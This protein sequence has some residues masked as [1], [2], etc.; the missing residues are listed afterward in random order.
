[1]FFVISGFVI[2]NSFLLGEQSSTRLAYLRDFWFRRF[3]RLWPGL[4]A[5]VATSSLF[6]VITNLARPGSLLTGLSSLVGLSNF[7]L[8]VGR[9]EYFALDTNSDWFMHLWSLSVEEQ[10]YLI[11][12]IV[13]M[14]VVP[15]N[16]NSEKKIARFRILAISLFFLTTISLTFALLPTTP[17]LI[18]FYSP[19]TRFY[20]VGF[21]ALIAVFAS[22]RPVIVKRDGPGWRLIVSQG[23]RISAY[24]GIAV[25]IFSD[26]QPTRIGS[27][28]MTAFTATAVVFKDHS[29]NNSSHLLSQLLKLVGDRSYSIYLV[30]W[31]IQLFSQIILESGPYRNL[32]NL[33]LTA[34][35][36][37]LN[38]R[39][40]EERFRNRHLTIRRKTA[41]LSTLFSVVTTFLVLAT[42]ILISEARTRP[43][44]S[45]PIPHCDQIDGSWWLIGD[46]HLA[47]LQSEISRVSGSQCKVIGGRGLVFDYTIIDESPDGRQSQRAVLND[48]APLIRKIQNSEN[49]PKVLLIAH[50]LSGYLPDPATAP[51]SSNA[52]A[53]EWS[54]HDGKKISRT[55][56]MA[57]F[58]RNLRHLAEVLAVRNAYLVVVS[59]PPDFD[60][61]RYYVDPAYCTGRLF[62]SRECVMTRS[63]AQIT[64]EEHELRSGEYRRLLNL[65]QDELPN[66]R[67]VSLDTPFCNRVQ[68]SNTINGRV[69]FGDDDHLNAAGAL[70]VGYK[71][72]EIAALLP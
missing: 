2:T 46:S 48:L 32:F 16:K 58:S 7:R 10:I 36:G 59:P 11:L 39:H 53:V 47:I 14:F 1:M 63:E 4:L 21:G 61:L 31:P 55:E 24:A 3:F 17:E 49:P 33:G 38:W 54:T 29:T 8:L 35:F 23:L 18:R 43:A 22:E 66:F 41:V 19:H 64:I 13:F 5:V 69:V 42:L 15:P 70:L 40:V 62:V 34:L 25:L 6:L 27:L 52:A 50:W 68:C 57:T 20:Q 44:S 37:S 45:R 26:L 72:D 30:H 12:S 9:L 60:W 67:H 56:F 71:F 28:L 65:M 51:K